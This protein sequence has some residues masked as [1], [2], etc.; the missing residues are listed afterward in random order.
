MKK[1]KVLI[2]L[3]I[4][5]SLFFSF[6]IGVSSAQSLEESVGEQLNNIDFNEIEDF[7]NT[8]SLFNGTSFLEVIKGLLSGNYNIDYSNVFSIIF[9]TFFSSVYDLLPAFLSIISIALFCSIINNVKSSFLSD[10]VTDV[11]YFVAIISIF[12]ILSVGFF[13][14]VNDSIA[15]A[16]NSGVL[17]KTTS[18]IILTLMFS[19]GS[20]VSASIYQPVVLFFSNVIVILV[21]N[22]ILP[23]IIAMCVFSLLTNLCKGIRL[24]K[25]IEFF[26]SILKWV[27]GI[28]ITVF[29]IFLTIQGVSVA[30]HD[31]I[32]IKTAKYVISNSIPIVGGLIKDGLGVITMSSILIKNAVGVGA[33]FAL[34]SLIISPVLSMAVYSLL[35]KLTGAI[36]D[37]FADRRIGE[38]CVSVSKCVSYL[39]ASVLMLGVMIFV[40]FLLMILSANSLI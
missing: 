18:P 5:F 16:G 3:F 40:T 36:V 1:Y 28:V 21:S 15:F 33:V 38:F 24:N 7:C 34:F 23:L 31:G 39:I 32:K 10:R 17:I 29:T 9:S 2:Y 37:C 6:N 27:F 14:F 30:I 25:F 11:I 4:I 13:S 19:T 12:L 8:Y 26:G 22:V 35:L 20:T